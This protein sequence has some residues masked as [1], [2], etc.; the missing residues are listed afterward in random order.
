MSTSRMYLMYSRYRLRQ[1]NQPKSAVA[2]RKI[3]SNLYA[4]SLNEVSNPWK[5]SSWGIKLNIGWRSSSH[6]ASPP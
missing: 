5:L 2:S 6:F 3:L 1:V 4:Q